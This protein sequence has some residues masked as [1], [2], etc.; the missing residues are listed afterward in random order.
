[1]NLKPLFIMSFLIVGTLSYFN[2]RGG[3]KEGNET[4][5]TN[6]N[7][8]EGVTITAE[9]EDEDSVEFVQAGESVQIGGTN[10]T[11]STRKLTIYAVEM[12]NGSVKE[13][14]VHSEDL[15]GNTFEVTNLPLKTFLRIE[16][17][18]EKGAIVQ[19]ILTKDEANF[20]KI[21]VLVDGEMTIALKLFDLILKQA[22]N[23]DQDA[24]KIVS[25]RTL[26]VLD[27]IGAGGAIWEAQKGKTGEK[28]ELN[29]VAADLTLS[30][31]NLVAFL[32]EISSETFAKIISEANQNT[33]FASAKVGT[34][35]SLILSQLGALTLQKVLEEQSGGKQSSELNP[36]FKSVQK[37]AATQSEVLAA[38]IAS[39]EI[40]SKQVQSY[41]ETGE[42]TQGTEE[43]LETKKAENIQKFKA[44]PEL[45][46]SSKPIEI[47]NEEYKQYV[48]STVANQNTSNT[49]S[50]PKSNPTENS[51]PDPTTTST[52]TSPTTT[53]TPTP[54]TTPTENPSSMSPPDEI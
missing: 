14:A 13:T 11:S 16:L 24:I 43:A 25:E 51:D 6:Q 23:G 54:T 29:T 46:E 50:T 18:D 26:N 36:G 17:N 30:T 35:N 21:R 5:N 20:A 19:P 34:P 37:L 44:N 28:I 31:K 1:M 42:F 40:A 9:V 52:V 38:F 12:N 3:T 49:N 22:K 32:P 45:I 8:E 41:S 33:I 2:C 7:S 10:L 27:L 4:S 48:E 15:V 53:S 47:S 39:Q